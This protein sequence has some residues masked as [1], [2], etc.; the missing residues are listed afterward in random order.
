MYQQFE[1]TGAYTVELKSSDTV[2]Y[3]VDEL[4]AQLGVKR[5]AVFLYAKTLCECWDWEPESV[6]KPS[7]GKYSQRALDEMVQLQKLGGDE[8]AR[9]V[10][11]EN[12]QSSSVKAVI[13]S[14]NHVVRLDKKLINLQKQATSTS[15]NL[16]DRIRAKLIE[17]NKNNQQAYQR[18]SALDGV[19]L[20]NAEN[21]GYEK[22]LEIFN[23][24]EKAKE[25]T[26]AQL[27]AMKLN[28]S[29][30]KNGQ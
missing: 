20:L 17:V 2:L 21:R 18:Q 28:V 25:E 12:H 13:P 1:E 27:R 22:A 26:L 15:G 19:E 9:V 6:F 30:D 14:T 7:F 10:K 3:T 11:K 8:Y 4:A 23:V 5:R 29:N 16:A 24:E